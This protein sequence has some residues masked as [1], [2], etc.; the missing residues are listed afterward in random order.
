[1]PNGKVISR[2]LVLG[3]YGR[4][5]CLLCCHLWRP[6]ASLGRWLGGRGDRH[7]ARPAAW[8]LGLRLSRARFWRPTAPLWRCR[9]VA[10]DPAAVALGHPAPLC[11]HRPRSRQWTYSI[12]AT[13]HSPLNSPDGLHC[14]DI[15]GVDRLMMNRPDWNGQKPR[16]VIIIISGK[17]SCCLPTPLR[18][19]E[20]PPC[21][22][23]RFED[24]YGRQTQTH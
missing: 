22:A 9:C 6:A 13:C 17:Q 15:L 14:I 23:L 24:G 19:G 21:R 5:R 16:F 8:A 7:L 3:W 11:R 12:V 2:L 1:M 18:H 4:R 20:L 10:L